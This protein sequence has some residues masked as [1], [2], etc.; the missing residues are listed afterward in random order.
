MGHVGPLLFAWSFAHI[1]QADINPFLG[2]FGHWETPDGFQPSSILNGLRNWTREHCQLDTA[3]VEAWSELSPVAVGLAVPLPPGVFLS[4]TRTR[5][6]CSSSVGPSAAEVTVSAE[7]ELLFTL[8]GGGYASSEHLAVLSLQLS[9][10]P[11]LACEWFGSIATPEGS[12]NMRSCAGQE[13][14][15]LHDQDLFDARQPDEAASSCRSHR[16]VYWPHVTRV[17]GRD[18]ADV[19]A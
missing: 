6:I 9:A 17:S 5:H 16:S 13:C 11:L 3:L 4:N 12:V 7:Q 19:S 1:A 8:S 10:A 18:S 14:V 15:M 2:W